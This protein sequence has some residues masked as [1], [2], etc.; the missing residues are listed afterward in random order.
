[1]FQDQLFDYNKA[2]F[3]II[4]Q[5]LRTIDWNRKFQGNTLDY[6]STLKSV[7]FDLELAHVPTRLI[8]SNNKYRKPMG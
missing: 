3:D 4:K 8:N 5:E 7:L 1:M 6:W 2:D